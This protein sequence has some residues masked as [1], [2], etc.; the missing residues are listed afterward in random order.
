M[1][2]SGEFQ[3]QEFLNYRRTWCLHWLR[4]SEES[5]GPHL[6]LKFFVCRMGVRW[7]IKTWSKCDALT[8]I[9]H[10]LLLYTQGTKTCTCAYKHT[11]NYTTTTIILTMIIATNYSCTKLGT[12]SQTPIW[13]PCL[14]RKR[15]RLNQASPRSNTETWLQERTKS[16]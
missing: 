9:P 6:G 3:S 12:M 15:V 16:S 8:F 7:H 14:V 11:H 4:I 2:L 5:C 13:G 10:Q 1:G